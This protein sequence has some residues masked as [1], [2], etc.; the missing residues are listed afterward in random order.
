[1]YTGHGTRDTGQSSVGLSLGTREERGECHTARYQYSTVQYSTGIS[2]FGQV[3]S[4]TNM[5]ATD[6]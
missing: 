1:M 4:V 2:Q 3:I 6:I 5:M